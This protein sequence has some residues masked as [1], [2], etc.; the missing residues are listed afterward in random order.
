MKRRHLLAAAGAAGFA[1][2]VQAQPKPRIGYL[3]GRSRATDSHLLEAVREGLK[4]AG[5]V[6]GQNVVMD[7]RWG[8]GRYSEMPK[9]AAEL[10]ATQPDLIIA[11]G[12]NPV[13]L[14]AKAATSTIPVVFVSGVDP[15]VLGLV[16]SLSRPDG[17][18]TGM[19]L[20]A[21]QLDAKRLELLHD[22]VPT[23]RKVAVLHNP[24]NPGAAE[25]MARTRQAGA[26]LG[27]ILEVVG[28]ASTGEIERGFQAI[29]AASPD[30]L[31]VCA[32][33]FLINSRARILK[34]AA[35]LRLPAIFP[36]REFALDGGLASYG[37]R[38]ADVY[39]VVG[40]YAGRILKGAKP[41][42]LP[43]QRPTSYE[44]VLNLKTAKDLGF[45]VPPII[46]TRADEVI[47]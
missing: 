22:M 31:A 7:V 46:I 19:T 33:A 37:T 47:E 39:R 8:D 5:F 44:L 20:L 23:A 3:S 21:N 2:A 16:K 12:G 27:F 26:A 30:A 4:S 6:D 18:L 38:W 15:V 1:P 35:E 24:N 25:E 11:V 17:N 42:D 29:A 9:M 32:D 43:V 41:A 14:A 45:T 28:A 40:T 36:A 13:G 10:A 34:L